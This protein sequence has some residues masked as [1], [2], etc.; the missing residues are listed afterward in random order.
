M[1]PD[2]DDYLRLKE[3]CEANGINFKYV[4]VDLQF[5][6]YPL[7]PLFFTKIN[8]AI[9]NQDK[10]D[11]LI[12]IDVD[13]L[14]DGYYYN[15]CTCTLEDGDKLG[16]FLSCLPYGVINKTIPGIGATTLELN[17]DRNSIIVVPTKSLAYYKYLRTEEEKGEY[18]CMYI[19]SPFGEITSDITQKDIKK[20]LELDN[21]KKKKFLVVADSLPKVLKAIGSKN[22]DNYFLMIDEIDT[23]QT[24]NC[25]RPS[26]EDVID[27]Y[28]LFKEENRAVVSATI[29]P[30]THPEVLKDTILTTKYKNNP[31]RNIQLR[32]TN[33]EDLCTIVTIFEMMDINPFDKIVIAYNS[34]DGILVCIELFLKL[35]E[36]IN[37]IR[38]NIGILCGEAS[39]EKAG[40]YYIEINADRTLPK[41]FVF[42]T[43]AYFVGVDIEEPYHSVAVSTF[44]QPFTLLSTN[45]LAQ[46]VG[47]CRVGALSETVIY[48]TKRIEV[49]EKFNDFKEKILKKA[50]VFTK[51]I[52]AFKDVL[53]Q[54]PELAEAEVNSNEII[55][56]FAYEKVNNDYPVKLLRANIN[57]EIV[58]SYFNIDALL[59]RWY[60]HHSLYYERSILEKE[61]K[62]QNHLIR[63][64]DYYHDYLE[65]QKDILA[66]VKKEFKQDKLDESLLDAKTKLMEWDKITSAQIKTDE[67]YHLIKSSSKQLKKFYERFKKFYPYFETEY[68]VDLLIEHHNDDERKYKTFNNSL[69]FWALDEKHPF[70]ILVI[71]KFG[72][73]HEVG[74]LEAGKPLNISTDDNLRTMK[75]IFD[76]FF[77]GYAIK[78]KVQK[79]LLKC[80]FKRS[81]TKKYF[82][83]IGLNPMEFAEPKTK[84][85]ES[86]QARELIKLFEL[87]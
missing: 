44:N 68:L 4:T 40:D 84:I 65:E 3:N 43:C 31:P 21:G 22:F 10:T 73:K 50:E 76:S 18:S 56:Y 49:K 11:A 54:A 16:D 35:S 70:K 8:G 47:R 51:A 28:T 42:M 81:R 87:Q 6:D 46:I 82:K 39:K 29:R 86:V 19:G 2:Y 1:K 13:E 67:L 5:D 77:Q 62:K 69:V 20:Y 53:V 60:L 17:S 27:Y 15:S 24:D 45:R 61:L 14:I 30:F 63:R 25:Y 38:D 85:H 12:T 26:L 58:P 64:N 33:N 34:L 32:H 79:E 71:E 55:N 37:G 80:F 59:E 36:G 41:Q 7:P 23:L 57:N 66:S 78:E 72:Y 83:V 75:I 52:Q 9:I 48:T 74:N